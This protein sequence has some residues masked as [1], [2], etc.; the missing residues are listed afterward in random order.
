MMQNNTF[1]K[2]TVSTNQDKAWKQKAFAKING[3][4]MHL[5]KDLQCYELY[6]GIALKNH[7]F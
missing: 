4:K 5:V 1:N 2:Q 7:A 3:K 6:G